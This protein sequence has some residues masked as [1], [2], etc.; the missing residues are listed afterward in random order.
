MLGEGWARPP[1]S[2]SPASARLARGSPPVPARGPACSATDPALTA[3]RAAPRRSR[4]PSPARRRVD[5]P[6]LALTKDSRRHLTATSTPST[7]STPSMSSMASM[8]SQSSRSPRS[9]RRGRPIDDD[10]RRRETHAPAPRRT[11]ATRP[12]GLASR[13]SPSRGPI[14]RNR[15]DT[16]RARTCVHRPRRHCNRPGG[17]ADVLAKRLRSARGRVFSHPPA[18]AGHPPGRRPCRPTRSR[19][20][21]APRRV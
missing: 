18:L 2:A 3:R 4:R 10:R 1:A 19:P 9:P 14:A 5:A 7:P 12:S 20:H 16:R 13:S 11:R 15:A 21:D 8:S 6:H 17:Q